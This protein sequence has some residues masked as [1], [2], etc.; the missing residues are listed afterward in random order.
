MLQEIL[1]AVP[2]AAVPAVQKAIRH[3]ASGNWAS[4]ARAMW[5]A[6]D[7]CDDVGNGQLAMCCTD[8]GDALQKKAGF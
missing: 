5:A 7:A 8:A 3:A 4:A 6:A 1:F 2:E